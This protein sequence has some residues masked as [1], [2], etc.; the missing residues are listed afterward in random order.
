M[1]YIIK[2]SKYSITSWID[3]AK[4][5]TVREALESEFL[6]AV[7]RPEKEVGFIRFRSFSFSFLLSL[8]LSFTLYSYLF[9]TLTF[10]RILSVNRQ[11]NHLALVFTNQRLITHTMVFPFEYGIQ[12][13]KDIELQIYRR[14]IYSESL[15]FQYVLICS[16]IFLYYDGVGR[17][18][19]QLKILPN[20]SHNPVFVVGPWDP[21]CIVVENHIVLN[22]KVIMV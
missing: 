15:L 8:S 21:F 18:T 12:G 16:H 6:Q 13:R 17:R 22:S 9:T 20:L 4:R 7:R 19:N 1:Q 2:Y 3:P 10:S 14:L 5:I 11:F